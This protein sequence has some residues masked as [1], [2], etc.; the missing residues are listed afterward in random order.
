MMPNHVLSAVSLTL[1]TAVPCQQPDPAAARVSPL[2]SPP[3]ELALSGL[4]NPWRT[5]LAVS[6]I[7]HD[8]RRD[9]VVVSAARLL[10]LTTVQRRRIDLEAKAVDGLPEGVQP[11]VA[12]SAGNAD[13]LNLAPVLLGDGPLAFTPTCEVRC[14]P[15]L[16]D[17]DDD[18]NLDLV[19]AQ[20]ATTHPFTQDV[21]YFWCPG[22]GQGSFRAPQPLLDI[23]GR[24]LVE[25]SGAAAEIGVAD[26]NGDGALDLIRGGS[27]MHWFAAA[28]MGYDGPRPLDVAG[29]Q[30]TPI[31]WDGDGDLDLLAIDQDGHVV[32]FERTAG[33]GLEFAAAQQLAEGHATSFAVSDWNLDER[34]DLIVVRERS[35]RSIGG[36]EQLTDSERQQKRALEQALELAE[37]DLDALVSSSPLG[38]SAVERRARTARTKELVGRVRSLAELLEPLRDRAG[39]SRPRNHNEVTV[40]VLLRQE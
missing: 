13:P 26:L 16:V 40:E 39:S 8:G 23:A 38:L 27:S 11:A 6:D 5:G 22:T 15:T 21:G 29:N 30:P 25:S 31:D 37:Q 24:P 33:A 4:G 3:A 10:A 36:P 20:A 34:L 7:D 12:T 32:W 9:V 17:L 18:G 35:R 28:D 14:H 1:A 2:F 19:V